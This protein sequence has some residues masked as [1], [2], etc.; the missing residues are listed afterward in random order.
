M[1]QSVASRVA[2]PNFTPQASFSNCSGGA[3]QGSPLQQ[4]KEQQMLF[5]TFEKA[6]TAYAFEP[7]L[8][9]SQSSGN[10]Q[11]RDYQKALTTPF[12]RS[13]RKSSLKA[14]TSTKRMTRQCLSLYTVMHF[15]LTSAAVQ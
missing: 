8:L 7:E 9:G 11:H 4:Q 1:P 15:A 14:S 12:H 13:C 3:V 5:T 2:T 6:D 10:H